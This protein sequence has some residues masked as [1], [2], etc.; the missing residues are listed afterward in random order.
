MSNDRSQTDKLEALARQALAGRVAREMAHEINDLLVGV[1]SVTTNA[2]NA[3]TFLEL[4]R[5]LKTSSEYGHKI[6]ALVRALQ[7]LLRTP[8]P[9]EQRGS[10]DVA[11]ALDQALFL[12]RKRIARHGVEIDQNYG[13]L[14]RVQADIAPLEQ[15]FIGL[16]DNALDAMPSRGVLGLTAEHTGEFVAVTVSDTGTG[17][18]PVDVGKVSE[19]LQRSGE[20]GSSQGE[21]DEL[22]GEWTVRGLGLAVA[23]STVRKYGGELT[24]HGTLGTGSRV[25]VRLSACRE[26]TGP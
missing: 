19:W 15:V 9:P 16:L 26:S 4:R 21:P 12:C 5:A 1:V 24:V 3:G 6:A 18:P 14:P 8:D 10:A 22:G 25:T 7:E 13:S 23:R 11:A 20:S 2:M 17:T